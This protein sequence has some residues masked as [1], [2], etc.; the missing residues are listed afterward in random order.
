M[1]TLK[2]PNA[3][4]FEKIKTYLSQGKAIT[5]KVRGSSMRVFIEGDRDLAVIVPPS[6][7]LIT[8]GA[9]ALAETSPNHY[10]L[11]RI[12]KIKDN[13]ITL[14]GDGNVNIIEH[15]LLHNIIGIATTFYRKGRSTPDHVT[16]YKW[17]IYSFLW[18]TLRPFRRY[19]LFIYRTFFL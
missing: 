17:K 9:V 14:Q 8:K 10:V 1:K 11:H 15:C 3:L 18:L 19:L 6:P 16:D 2:V 4:L 12:I 7:N 13:N 5:I